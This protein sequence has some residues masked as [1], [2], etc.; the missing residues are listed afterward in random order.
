MSQPSQTRPSHLPTSQMSWCQRL[1]STSSM[2]ARVLLTRLATGLRPSRKRPR[3]VIHRAVMREAQEV[4]SLRLAHP[5]LATVHYREPAKLHEAGLVPVKAETELRRVMKNKDRAIAGGEP[6]PSRVEMAP[7]NIFFAH[8]VVGEE[9]VGCL[10]VGPVLASQRDALSEPGFHFLHQLAKAAV[11]PTVAKPAAGKLL[12]KPSIL[13]DP[14]LSP[15]IRCQTR[16]HGRF[17]QRKKLWNQDGTPS[18]CG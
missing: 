8:P 15:S 5:A 12:V 6:A 17:Q 13:H 7:K 16:N 4:E 18:R 3:R 9:A 2:R 11:Q 14:H 10:R 1:R